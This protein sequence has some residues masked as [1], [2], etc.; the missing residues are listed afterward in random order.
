M[1]IQRRS[2]LGRVWD[3]LAVLLILFVAY[4][5]FIAPRSLRGADASPAPHVVYQTLTGAPFAL[6]AHRG[7]VVFLD[8]FA[9]WCDPCKASLPLVEGYARA[10]REIDVIP[11]DVGEP[12]A[13]V[14]AFAQSYHLQNVAMDPQAL[15]R[16][17]FSVEGFPT[18]VVIDPQGKIRASWQGFNPAIQLNMANAENQL[19]R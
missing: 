4:R 9:S 12:R 6:T 7:R 1:K 17:L 2:P 11:V 13:V 15:A 10:H 16:G 3:A 8:F 19:R 14:A 18:T 5:F